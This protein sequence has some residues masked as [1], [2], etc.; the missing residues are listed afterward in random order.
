MPNWWVDEATGLNNLS[1]VPDDS[2]NPPVLPDGVILQFLEQ[3][4]DAR[5]DFRLIVPTM[6]AEE[7]ARLNGLIDANPNV[8]IPQPP[9]QVQEDRVQRKMNTTGIRTVGRWGGTGNGVLD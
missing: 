4:A 1:G 8:M 2:D 5:D 3:Y 7:Q 9:P 6:T